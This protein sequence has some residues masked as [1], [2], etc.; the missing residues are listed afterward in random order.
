MTKLTQY[1]KL[2]ITPAVGGKSLLHN[3]LGKLKLPPKPKDKVLPPREFDDKPIMIKAKKV[4]PADDD[5]FLP[6]KAN[7]A[8]VGN[9]DHAWYDDV[10]VVDNNKTVDIDAV[11]GIDPLNIAASTIKSLFNKK[12]EELREKSLASLNTVTN[13]EEFEDCK[14]SVF[15]RGGLF[16]QILGQVKDVPAEEQ[17]VINELINNYFESLGF[18]FDAKYYELTSE[19]EEEPTEDEGDVQDESSEPNITLPELEEG[20]LMI[21][22]DGQKQIILDSEEEARVMLSRLMLGN[23]IEVDRIRLLKRLSVDFG[24]LIKS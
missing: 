21:I 18:E 8:H 9:I 10:G 4:E 3:E 5:K 1:Q 2:D 11:Q 12:L 13:V 15:G 22:V 23:N 24:V 6:P 7:F 20:Q 19:E 17:A 16:S 14:G